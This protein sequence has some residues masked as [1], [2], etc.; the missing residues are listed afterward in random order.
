[1]SQALIRSFSDI[2]TETREQTIL[3]RK[4]GFFYTVERPI[5]SDIGVTPQD[6]ALVLGVIEVGAL[7]CELG[8][9]SENQITVG[10]ASW[11]QELAED[12]GVESHAV[13]FPKSG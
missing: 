3:L 5:D 1:M 4:Q 13:P 11:N 12:L 7:V 2:V 8:F 9:L 10:K 6:P